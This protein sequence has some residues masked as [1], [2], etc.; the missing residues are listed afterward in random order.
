MLPCR[1]NNF[2]KNHTMATTRKPS[3]R[4]GWRPGSGAKPLPPS[5][6]RRRPVVVALTDAQ[7]EKLDR[8]AQ[9]EGYLTGAFAYM[10]VS[11]W[12]ERRE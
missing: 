12:L 10:I 6:R 5:E 4:G 3:G 11:R 8:I 7:Y 9:R 2:K 1:W